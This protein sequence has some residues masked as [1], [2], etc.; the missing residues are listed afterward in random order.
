MKIFK[1]NAITFK[2]KIKFITF[3]L[4]GGMLLNTYSNLS[5]SKLFSFFAEPDATISVSSD[6]V[7]KGESVTITFE[8]TGG[9]APYTFTYELNEGDSI[10]ITTAADNNAIDITLDGAT[11]GDFT[12]K[13]TNVQDSAED[14]QAITV[15]NQEE[16]ITVNELPT[17]DFSFNDDNVC[18]GE[19]IRFTN[20][21][22]VEGSLTYFWDFGDGDTS[23]SRSPNHVFEEFGCGNKNFDVKLTVTDENGCSSSKSLLVNVKRKPTFEI[24]DA[25]DGDNEFSKCGNTTSSSTEF[26]ITLD[27]NSS[28]NCITNYNIKWGDGDEEDSS[29][30]PISHNY[31]EL[32][33]YDMI[34]E[35]T[36]S[37]GCTVIYETTV[38]NISNPSGSIVNPGS[39]QN[40]CA[41]TD[42][43]PFVISSW[44]EN[45]LDTTYEINYG[46]GTTQL[47][48]Q[49]HLVTVDSL[50]NSSDPA[51]SINI[52]IPH[53]Y[54]ESSCPGKYT[55]S[56]NVINA[57]GITPSLLPKISVL[58]K[59]KLLFSFN[60]KS[61]VNTPVIF[62]NN[63]IYGSG[64]G[65]SESGRFTWDF[66][67]GTV[68]GSSTELAT[69]TH[70]YSAPG[71]Y[72]VTLS[73]LSFCPTDPVTKE[74]CIEPEITPTFS[75]DNQEG[76]VPLNVNTINTTDES[77]LCSNPTYDWTVTYN[78][79]NCGSS[80]DWEFINDT[81]TSSENPEFIFK[82]PGEYTL[83]QR[84]TTG[85]G[86]EIAT[87]IIDV[88][89][90]PTASI[91]SIENVC[92][93]ATINPIGNVENCTSNND[94]ISYNWTFIG[95]TPASST[96]LDPG[97]IV[98]NNAGSYEVTLEV[99]SECG[100]SNKAT[101]TFRIFEIPIITNTDT[102][103]EICSG[104]NTTEIVLT[105]NTIN[106]NYS[107][108]AIASPD[109]T[110]FIDSGD[111]N[112]IYSQRLVNSGNS[113]GTVKYTVIPKL[114]NC[115]GDAFDFIATVNPSPIITTQPISSEVCL[116]GAATILEV[117]Y[118]KGTATATYEWFSNITDDT[119]SGSIIADAIDSSYNPPTT[120]AGETFYYVK[121]S[122]PTS[123]CAQIVSNTASVI[124]VPQITVAPADAAQVICAGGM[125][126][127][128]VVAFSGGTG[129]PSYQWFSN[130]TNLNTGG[131]PI[132]GAT[133]STYTPDANTFTNAGD[134][135]Y[136]A[137][138]SLDGEG[139]N[140][141]SSE[142]YE[143]NVLADPIIDT[144]AIDAQELCQNATPT[145]LT[146]IVSGGTASA[147]S[148]QWFSNTT[149]STVD[150]N[151]ISGATS[152]TY[153][154][155]TSTVGT[156]YYYVIVSQT[157]SGCSV[158][159]TVSELKVNEAPIV[160]TQPTSS[161]ICLNGTATLLEVAYEKGTGTPEFQ[162]FSNVNNF[163]SGGI[164]I[165]DATTASFDPPTDAEGTIY[166]YVEI[167]FSSGGCAQIVSNTASVIVVPQITIAPA[168][169]A[170]VICAG[171]TA[172]ELVVTFSGGTGTP[173]YQWFSN[174]T[175]ANTDGALISGATNNT[176]IPEIFT[177][178]G[179]FYYYAEISLDG[180]GCNSASSGVYE[181]NVLSDPI[182]DTQAIDAQELCQNATPTDLTVIVSGGTASAKSYQ[183][184]ETNTNSIA[185][186]TPISGATSD[187]YTPPTSTVGT[188]YHYVIVSQDESGCSVT[189]TVSELKVNEA[190]IV[191]TQPTSS[192]IC[193]NGTATL[194]EVT[195][196]KG[197][198]TP[199]FQWFSNMTNTNSGG[200]EIT[201]ATTASFDPPT[202]VVGTIYYY[203]EIS[204]SSGGCA[205]IDSNTASVVIA[206][207]IRV[208]PADAAQVICV[209]GTAN[210]LVVT[211][212]GGTGT[213]SYQWFSNTTKANTDGALISGATNNTYIPEIFTN[214]GDFYYY[215]EISLDGE[216]CNSASSEV[217]EINVLEDPVINTQAIDAQEL[218]QNATPTDL[219]VI[220]SGG[221]TS[222]K[223]Y[224]WYQNIDNNSTNG[225]PI[226]NENSATFT[227]STAA[228]GTFYY[229]VIISQAESGCSVI[230]TISELKV[231]EA[232]TFTSQ[233]TS[234]EV[235]LDETANLLQ[236][237]YQNGT[238][239]ASYQWFYNIIDST[240]GG[241]PIVGE[242]NTSYNPLTDVV[243]TIYYYVEISFSSGGCT[244][245]V[246]T[247]ASVIVNE[248][249]VISS[250]EITM[251]SEETF[252]FNPNTIAGNTIPNGTKYTWS[253][254]DFN[255]A[256][257]IIG[258]SAETNPQD[259][260]SQT[261]ENTG[262]SPV[263]V[264]YT[265]T[266]AT[267]NCIGESFI[268]E[269][270]VNPSINSNTVVINNSC[271]ESNDASITTNSIG[272]VP[273]K[274]GNPYLIFWTG[275]NGFTATNATILNLEAGLYILRIED[276]T[277][278]FITEEWRV[279][280]PDLLVITKDVEK[281]IS[282]FQGNDGAI[283]VTI[284]G[285]TMPYTFNWTTSDG[286]GIVLNTK[287][288]NILTAGSY[289]LEIIDKNNC[290][291][292]EDFILTEPEGLKIE[293]TFKQ[294]ILCFGDA[295]GAIEI[296]VSGGTKTETSSGIFDYLYS[297]SGPN[298]FTSSSKNINNLLVGT[299][300]VAVTDNLGC[301]INAEIIINQ[302]SEI[303][304]NYIKTDVT[305]Y[306]ET[307]GSIDVS[308]IGGVAP[309]Q[310]SWSSLANGFSLSNLS[311]D[312]YIATITDGN[313]CV[314][315]VSII[316]EQ[317]LFFIDPVVSPISCNDENDGAIDLNLTGGIA[318]FFVTWN[319]DASAGVQRN[320]LAAG[321]YTVIIIDSDINQ[322]PIEQTFIFTNPSAIAVSTT[323]V[324]AID[325]DIV[326]SGRIDLEI[327]GGTIPYSFLW[328]NNDT[329][330]DLEDIPPGDYSVEITDANGCK[331][332]RQFNIFRQ[333]PLNITFEE[334]TITDCDLKTVS[335]QTE[336]I[337][338][339][340]Y[341]P[342]SYS[343]SAGTVSEPDNTM[344]TTSQNGS[345]NLT[346]TDKQG[347][348]ESKSF[349]VDVPTI[350]DIDF[351]YNA[352]ALT[353][354]DLLSIED[355]IQFT[356]LSTG[357]FTSVKWDFGDGSPTSNEENSIHTYDAVGSFKV[358]LTIVFNAGCTEIFERTVAITQGYSL[359][360]PTAFTPN[361]DGYNETIRPS[362]RGF[363]NLKMTI[364]NTWGTVVYTEE[365]I[366]LTGWNG[367]LG[368]KPAE[369]GNYLMVVKGI[370]FYEKEIIKSSPVTL[371]K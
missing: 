294:E 39:T 68:S 96:L 186:G 136:Y 74:I 81:D 302:S 348:T 303:E 139:C 236:V 73:V 262:T 370:T 357:D 54:K 75:V 9:D 71:T 316:I 311:A 34:I 25:I 309:Y 345:Y 239:I 95:G 278:F 368:N 60:D 369:N 137:E 122:F 10:E 323:V 15:T 166:Y 13:L 238:G 328:N 72:T 235:C 275:P 8:A 230:S 319:D 89:E 191:S 11:I 101:Q 184:Y 247:T 27:L 61:C 141:A 224:Q 182:I 367:V 18:S 295:T 82:N 83:I 105:S 324:N 165:T 84:I 127:E 289:R 12:Y 299:Y 112:K 251:Y 259:Q 204:F 352:F 51:S 227:P 321:T 306:G 216:G 133:N 171:G 297:W 208:A 147:K 366:N 257:S 232:P 80:E 70:I 63:S 243:G 202:D 135:Y 220:V 129:T 50:Y 349:I 270:T 219:T 320:N 123:G 214:A 272:G 168:D 207:Q 258:A 152:D 212:S 162:W 263:K 340:G 253:S 331:V 197:T 94:A 43:I 138:I 130:S 154:P 117:A 215:A 330:E 99:T 234:S 326:N 121:I 241:S 79:D 286:S 322:C 344:M 36:S 280:Q 290:I 2:N 144:Q 142:V 287:N 5:S 264:R 317:P 185:D 347:C 37:N 336:A 337:V 361:N 67:D 160:S 56:L 276:R 325:C 177:N 254:P 291:I 66:G 222:N 65:C 6:E 85:C 267:T 92:G 217:Y 115:E 172:N 146:V 231:N 250:A 140:S 256:G 274:T 210:E 293:T 229:Y 175:E 151:S 128:L 21:S 246:S 33:V 86:T 371:L 76:C 114:E 17:V 169:A 187:T 49:V 19:T 78:P 58:A 203:V 198:G 153:T 307:N 157:E 188:F 31:I 179:D 362:S 341:L 327:S 44:G 237:D 233:P 35:A 91:D 365:G 149:S 205:Q 98:Y 301:K 194:L 260:I 107:W 305:C 296:D 52:P 195:Y 1:K 109:I 3:F 176:Y 273:F 90:P 180:E 118:E 100:L 313:N 304:I 42:V 30:F 150:G 119:S 196:E 358:L 53:I 346:I 338:T 199:E 354:Y 269:V 143:I 24:F 40:I 103:Q 23:L 193:L 335:K 248:I 124:V 279:T 333:E 190:P 178:A 104:Q 292:I 47:L 38:K 97:A 126:N 314:K 329:T 29:T 41:P 206:P 359:I 28:A 22:N 134:F 334:T 277:G 14:S 174:T 249:P 343:W 221:S 218:C 167:S 283:A 315:Q 145:D 59:P 102:T 183:W 156:F 110:G 120:V 201:D 351:R 285:G 252:N 32:G 244:Q 148:Y 93:T 266:P 300:K 170:Q 55:A 64:S 132:N 288:Q 108:T 240:I 228:I 45:S 62:D 312:T 261:L 111:S 131:D 298:G 200:I 268:L 164:E 163:N 209:G 360:H 87:K 332:V 26:E 189:S 355:P 310:I 356:N 88:K 271:F 69:Q 159:S 113:V 46:D 20:N 363:T 106:T 225:T 318:P 255:P 223:T 173:S 7:C 57:C 4:V 282:C 77:D 181:I 350:G 281:N 242:T 226:S 192:E 364:Y 353:T 265:I 342:Y 339:G 284:S 48:T 308:V 161:E 155:P 245:I 158:T 125:A 116:E 211:F 213:P 16:T